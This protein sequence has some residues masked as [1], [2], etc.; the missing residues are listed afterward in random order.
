MCGTV[1]SGFVSGCGYEKRN[2][3]FIFLSNKSNYA[4]PKNLL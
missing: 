4:N 2:I 1:I 3:I